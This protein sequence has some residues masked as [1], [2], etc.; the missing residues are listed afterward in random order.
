MR[1]SLADL[2]CKVYTD[3]YIE[4]MVE[5]LVSSQSVVENE[6]ISLLLSIDGLRHPLLKAIS[7]DLESENDDWILT[8][9][10][11]ELRSRVLKSV[12]HGSND[13]S[14]VLTGLLKPSLQT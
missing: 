7:C 11:A 2:A 12:L 4:V 14:R 6:F 8:V 5:A 9:N 13:D 3:R 1:I 10:F